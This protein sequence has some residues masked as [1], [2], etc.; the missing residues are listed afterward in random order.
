MATEKLLG[1]HRR[2]EDWVAWLLG[3]VIMVSPWIVDQSDHR[4]AVV[5][6]SLVGL[7][8]LIF[9]GLEILHNHR[10]YEYAVLLLG[11]WLFAAPFFLDYA[12]LMPLAALHYFLGAI[13]ALLA[14]LEIW[15]DKDLSDRDLDEQSRQ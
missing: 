2:W 1:R 8:L 6:A 3:A 5:N 13:V 10:W 9:A 12:N 4:A 7:A 15:Q 14:V 11:V